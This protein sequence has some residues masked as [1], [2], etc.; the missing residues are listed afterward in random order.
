MDRLFWTFFSGNAPLGMIKIDRGWGPWG[1]T[2]T[3]EGS[4]KDVPP[5]GLGIDH[6]YGFSL[7]LIYRLSSLDGGK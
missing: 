7:G 6:E 5:A 3:A 4:G 1:V 2:L